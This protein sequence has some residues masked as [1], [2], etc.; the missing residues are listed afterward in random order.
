M[1]KII[2][3]VLCLVFVLAL[4]SCG[5]S[6]KD[7]TTVPQV[8]DPA[9]T[10]RAHSEVK[11]EPLKVPF[12][13]TVKDVRVS[14]ITVDPAKD[15][16]LTRTFISDKA[17]EIKAVDGMAPTILDAVKQVFDENNIKY[18]IK[19]G[20]F[21]SIMGKTNGIKDGYN[22]IW[23]FNIGGSD[24]PLINYAA[25]TLIKEGDQIVLYFN[26]YVVK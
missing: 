15:Y 10:T 23:E 22:Y 25:S 5:C 17:S 4:S 14:V 11:R 6:K 8:T 12:E 7:E 26:P 3:I 18:E 21:T 2:S 9:N 1:K 13:G 19:D 16:Y 20:M 24:N